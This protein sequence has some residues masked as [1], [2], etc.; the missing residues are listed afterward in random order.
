MPRHAEG[1][2]KNDLC[3]AWADR[4]SSASNW[5]L[6]F[7]RDINRG[8]ICIVN[9]NRENR[10]VVV[11]LHPFFDSV[12]YA[13]PVPNFRGKKEMTYWQPTYQLN[14]IP[15]HHYSPACMYNCSA[16]INKEENGMQ[17]PYTPERA[18]MKYS[19]TISGW[20]LRGRRQTTQ[21][22]IFLQEHLHGEM[23]SEL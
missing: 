21:L 8:S 20:L 19:R 11:A 15:W 6:G 5:R 3:G 14:R 23:Y 18:C 22:H 13:R 2:R 10:K 1:Q 12:Q 17:K 16:T 9:G 4:L 7:H